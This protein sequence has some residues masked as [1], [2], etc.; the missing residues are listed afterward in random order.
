MVRIGISW[1]FLVFD[2]LTISAFSRILCAEGLLK[3]AV[4]DC[5]LTA[6]FIKQFTAAFSYGFNSKGMK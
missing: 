2:L 6:H 4:C 3:N 1:A 5:N